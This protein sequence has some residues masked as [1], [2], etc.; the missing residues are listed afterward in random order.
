MAIVAVVKKVW[1]SFCSQGSVRLEADGALCSAVGAEAEAPPVLVL[2]PLL[3]R[4]LPMSPTRAKQ[5][6]PIHSGLGRGR[7]DGHLA[8]PHVTRRTHR[9]PRAAAHAPS[10][11]SPTT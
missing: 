2:L 3:L 1:T 11:P 7:S 6:F 10:P 8:F 5:E 9:R 4:L